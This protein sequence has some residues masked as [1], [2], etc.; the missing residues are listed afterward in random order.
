M[1]ADILITVLNYIIAGF[2]YI[3]NGILAVLP[4]SPFQMISNSGVAEYLGYLNWIIP[5]ET[6]LTIAFYWVTAIA[7]YYLYSV[8]LRWIKVIS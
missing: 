7:V 3:A 6:L 2:A 4:N 1:I 5:V 8:I